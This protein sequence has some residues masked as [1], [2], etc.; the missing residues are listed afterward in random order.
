MMNGNQAIKGDEIFGWRKPGVQLSTTVKIISNIRKSSVHFW[1]SLKPGDTFQL[2]YNLN[3]ESTGKMAD[4]EV[5]QNDEKKS[6]GKAT[7]IAKNLSNFEFEI[8]Q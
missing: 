6:T 1:K 8:L 7:H 2:V 5:W 4:V 3:T